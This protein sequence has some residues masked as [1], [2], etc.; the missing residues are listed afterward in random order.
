M[1]DPV[2]NEELNGLEANANWREWR[3][4][5]ISEL[6][7]LNGSVADLNRRSPSIMVYTSPVFLTMIGFTIPCFLILS[8]NDAS[9][10]ISK[11]VI[12]LVTFRRYPIWKC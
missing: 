6:R 8:R 1:A 12:S 3:R 4:L 7:R 2:E 10:S 9:L 5:L 11:V